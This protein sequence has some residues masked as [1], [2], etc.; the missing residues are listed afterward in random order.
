MYYVKDLQNK[1]DND[2]NIIAFNYILYDLEIGKFRKIKT[3][4]F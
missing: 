3:E 1:I 2:K 4:D